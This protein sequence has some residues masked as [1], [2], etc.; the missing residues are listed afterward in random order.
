VLRE[1]FPEPRCAYCQSPER[2]LGIPLEVDHITPEAAGGQTEL[3]NLCLCC[4]SCNGYK[5]NRTQARDPQT[6][7][8]VRLFHPR[9][10]RWAAHFAWSETGTRII[11]LTATG[12]ATVEALHMNNN[13][14]TSLR[15]LWIML[16]LHPPA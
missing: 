4:R 14:I 2:L 7:R 12:R 5:W 10:Q 8:R 3:D 6:N 16:R 11:R 15:Q 9:Q 1:E 13:L